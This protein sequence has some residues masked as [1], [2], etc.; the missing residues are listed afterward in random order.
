MSEYKNDY[1]NGERYNNRG[2]DAIKE[3]IERTRSNMSR[4]IDSIQDRLNPDNLKQQA[5]DALRTTV[6]DSTDALMGY[7]KDNTGDLSS[8]LVNAVK[9]NSVP[10]ALIGLGVAWLLIDSMSGSDQDYEDNY[11]GR[12]NGERNMGGQGYYG[13]QYAGQQYG[14]QANYQG[15]SSSGYSQPNAW[16]RNPQAQDQWDDTQN[17]G[18]N[19]QGSGQGSQS[20]NQ[21]NNPESWKDKAAGVVDQVKDKAADVVDQVKDKASDL[22]EGVKDTTGQVADQVRGGVQQLGEQTRN[23]ANQMGSYTQQNAQWAGQQVQHTIESNPFMVGAAA[24]AIGAAVGFFL[25]ATSKENELMGDLR[26]QV[27]EKAQNVA[28]D[29]QQR[30]QKVVEEVKPEVE[31]TA[32]KLVDSLKQTGQEAVQELKQTA[33]HTGETAK[34]EAKDAAQNAKDEF[35]QTS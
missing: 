3:D 5:S 24:L 16:Q 35:K 12:G 6:T 34:Q 17:M 15:G 30:V 19:W 14:G 22:V 9:R 11:R 27:F 1:T 7:L 20:W 4:K 29:V 26:N 10:A 2:S 33:Q 23:Q 28:Q 25:P 13:Q 32:N 31:Q 21:A 8:T 18:S